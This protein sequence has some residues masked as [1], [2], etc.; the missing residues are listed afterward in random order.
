[1]TG[2]LGFDACVDHR[3]P[4]LAADL[5]AACPKGIDVYFENVGGAVF[6][7]VLPLFNFFA[8]MPVCGLIAQYNMAA[9]PDGPDTRPLLMRSVLTNRLK[10]QGFIVRDRWERQKAFLDEV[11]GYIRDGR[12][13]YR[14][15]IADGLENA[16]AT[17]IGLLEGRNF[18]KQLVRVS[19]DPTRG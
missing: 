1:M 7:A 4:T 12:L 11:G 15:D 3:S 17:L 2:E 6:A 13:K 5:A 14:E 9:L 19:E 16:P 10:I 8:R 18:G